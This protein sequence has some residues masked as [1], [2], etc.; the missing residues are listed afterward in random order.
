MTAPNDARNELLEIGD[1]AVITARRWASEAA[2]KPVAF[3]SRLLADVLKD[4]NGL[5]FTVRF[6]D[7]VIRPQDHAAAAHS[8]HW[9]TRR[10]RFHFLPRYLGWAMKLAGQLAPL[11]PRLVIPA[12]RAVFRALV[13][14]LVLDAGDAT[15]GKRLAAKRAD[16]SRLNVNL[17]GEAVLGDTEAA[18]RLAAN[19]A[20]LGRDDVDYLS[21]KISAVVGPHS[22]WGLDEEVDRAVEL[23]LPLYLEAA[24][25]PVP[26]FINLDMEDHKDIA[27]TVTAF[28]RVLDDPRLKD[29]EAGI[30]LQAYM[31]DSFQI[32]KE[33]QEWA[34]RRVAG[35]GAPIKV[36]LVKGANLEMER[37]DAQMRGW[38]LVTWPTKQE[39]DT[40]FKRVLNWALTPERTRNIRIGVASQNL[41]DIAFAWH[42]AQRRGVTAAVE[43]EMLSGM[44][45]AQ[46]DVV[47]RD[48]GSLVLYVPVV[49][50]RDFD[51]A[52][53]YLVRRLE[54]NAAADNFMS[55][56]FDLG[57]KDVVFARE[58]DRFLNSLA[59]VDEEIPAPMRTQDRRTETW[60]EIAA[61]VRDDDGAWVFRNTPDTDPSLP[62]N[63]EWARGIVGRIPSSTLG[64]ATADAAVVGT[65][66]D[67]DR[68]VA[69][70][71]A[72]GERWGALP[73]AERAEIV[74]RV[75]VELGLRR[76]ELLEVA[77]AEAGKTLDQGDPEVSEAIDFAHYYAQQA[78]ELERVDGAR[79]V[80]ARLTVVTPP[81]NFP[82]AIPAGGVLA[83]LAAGSAVILKPATPARRCGAV[84]AEAMWAAGVPRDV[85]RLVGTPAREV[86]RALISHPAVE[87]V[88]LTGSYETAKLFRSW[89]ADLPLLAETSGKNTTIVTPSADPDLA[90]R[91]VVYSAFGHAGQ[92][93]SASSLLIL[94]GSTGWSRRIHSQLVDAVRS[95]HVA[96]PSDPSAQMGPL[97]MPD[98]EKL[99][100][101]LTQ[102]GEGERWVLRPRQLDATGALWSPGIRAGVRPGSEYHLVE[103]FGPILGVMR[104]RTLAEAID[105]QNAVDY[106]LTAGLQTLDPAEL[107]QWLGSVEAG[108]LYVNRVITGAIVRRQPFGGWKRSAVGPGAKA[109][110]PSY[111]FALG[112]WQPLPAAGSLAADVPGLPRAGADPAIEALPARWRPL[113]RAADGLR[114]TGR[115]DGADITSLR[116]A[117]RSDAAAWAAQFGIIH[118]P[119]GLTLERNVLRYLPTAVTVRVDEDQRLTDLLRVLGGGI[120]AQARLTLST[121][122]PLPGAVA[123]ALEDAGVTVR[124]ETDKEWLA[125]AARWAR[126]QPLGGRVRL[127]GDSR[128]ALAAATAGLPDI[129]VWSGPVTEAGRVEMLPFVHE[130]SVSVTAHRFGARYRF[131][132]RVL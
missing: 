74:H 5:D 103:Y 10:A 14:D 72:A 119:T 24:S 39:T 23:L 82:I 109:G 96:W 84:L 81:W 67:M 29:L 45:P 73:A 127:V 52:I 130:Q 108:N 95:L 59:R 71:V 86:G 46:A 129:A 64:T 43:F 125:A 78:L 69:E 66:A 101:G 15:L 7:T 111:L 123:T 61:T 118:D 51:V 105:I 28:R 80:P 38:P 54:E 27:L 33:L 75:G 76:G 60:E 53:A 79:F 12:V 65:V 34:S 25:Y 62:G 102:L 47:S 115:M 22:P 36:R 110:G 18:K 120:M 56:V 126:T 98:D 11:A 132:E 91:D 44:A 57:R 89:R 13:G 70:S 40:H 92:K 55:G 87:R 90:V 26:K 49:A 88:I 17:L 21:L 63:L 107:K 42:M 16:G 97:V 68:I 20:L 116:R 58:R 131:S 114:A 6:V 4:N 32:L 117:A 106:G 37:L 8:L 35:G 83:A 77:A 104:A 48:V 30:A 113:L 3:T 99:R 93:C 9:R 19:S 94:V 100:R 50:P 124:E 122:V 41:F 128:A 31:P 1:D 85:L 2:V 112:Q 121:G